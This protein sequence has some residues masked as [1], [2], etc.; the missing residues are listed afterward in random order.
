MVNL[1]FVVISFMWDYDREV[2]VI[3]LTNT[4]WYE[5]NLTVRPLLSLSLIHI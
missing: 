5:Y 4:I 2:T 1:F 3:G